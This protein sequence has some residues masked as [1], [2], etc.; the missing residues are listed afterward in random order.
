MKCQYIFWKRRYI[1][2]VWFPVLTLA[3]CCLGFSPLSSFKRR[4][5]LAFTVIETLF[6]SLYA[7]HPQTLIESTDL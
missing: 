5:H 2:E 7:H 3:P 6:H 1:F 4:K